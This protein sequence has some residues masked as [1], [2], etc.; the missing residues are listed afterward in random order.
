M[1]RF[2]F[3]VLITKMSLTAMQ[4]M[5]STHFALSSASYSTNPRMRFWEKVGVKASGVAK[6][7]AFLELVRL[8]TVRGLDVPNG[9][10][11]GKGNFRKIFT[12]GDGR[13]DKFRGGDGEVDEGFWLGE[14]GVGDFGGDGFG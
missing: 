1:L 8:E 9:I 13:R 7:I 3:H 5:V 11:V 4:V 2:S 6:M 12:Y 10:E 14:R